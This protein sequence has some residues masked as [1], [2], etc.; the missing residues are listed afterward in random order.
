MVTKEHKVKKYCCFY[1]SDFHLEMILL[2]YIKK[3]L[4]KYKFIIMTETNLVDSINLLLDRI[5]LKAEEKMEILKLNWQ[6]KDCIEEK[7]LNLNDLC[8]IINGSMD[9]INKI[10]KNIEQLKLKNINI[11][12]CYKIDILS[13]NKSY[14]GEK[15]EEIL[16]T[17]NI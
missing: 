16:N 11:I 6:S 7:F 14:L 8:F 5:N 13:E 17:K 3:N 15:Y 1:A 9:Y 12:D 10:N 4:K 2:P